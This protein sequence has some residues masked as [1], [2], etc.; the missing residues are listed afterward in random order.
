MYVVSV[1]A[2]HN[3]MALYYCV[4]LVQRS[5]LRR[6]FVTTELVSLQD[7]GLGRTLGVLDVDG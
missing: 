7:E 4:Y 2:Q 5:C 6:S 3:G 1:I